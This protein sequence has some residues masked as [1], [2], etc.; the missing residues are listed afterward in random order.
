MDRH[1]KMDGAFISIQ[2]GINDHRLSASVTGGAARCIGCVTTVANGCLKAGEV[3]RWDRQPHSFKFGEHD[4]SMSDRVVELK[5]LF[6]LEG[7]HCVLALSPQEGRPSWHCPPVA[8]HADS[9]TPS[10]TFA[11]L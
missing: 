4:N 3:I 9:C 1:V 6:D 5:A 11:R 7:T 2:N 8:L 10:D